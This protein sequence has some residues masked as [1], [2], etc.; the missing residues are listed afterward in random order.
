MD[1]AGKVAVVTG[2]AGGIGK[3]VA[4]RMVQAGARVA[5]ADLDADRARAA[6]AEVGGHGF[7]C[8]VSREDE[9]R[10]LIADVRG[11][12]GEIDLFL[13]NAGLG[14]GDPSH[15][16][17]APNEAWQTS[18]DVHVMAHV[19]AARA[20]LPG[21]IARGDGYLIN[22][23]SAAGLL[24]QIGDA[25]YSVTKHAGSVWPRRWRSATAATGSRFR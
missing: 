4:R 9:V 7:G 17:S 5:L 12:L 1:L 6:G 11:D 24:N 25:A 19:W 10:R 13:S 14:F 16:A 22:T 3:A 8:D 18:W 15:A 21:M 23:A 20:L 2:G